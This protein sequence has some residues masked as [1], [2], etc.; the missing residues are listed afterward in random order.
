MT[1]LVCVVITL[2]VAS[3]IAWP[4]MAAETSPVVTL[5][6]KSDEL[7]QREKSVALVAIKEADFDKATGKLS[8]EDY[9]E[10]RYDYEERA[11]QAMN[12]LD[13]L[14]SAAREAA[15]TDDAAATARAAFCTACGTRFGDEHTFCASCGNPRS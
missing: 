10:L 11:L 12:E 4:L 6:Q 3:A 9:A 15:A 8:D 1:T 7:W 13:R 5:K 2:A 14:D